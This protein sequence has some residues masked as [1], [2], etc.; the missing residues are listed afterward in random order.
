[1]ARVQLVRSNVLLR[2]LVTFVAVVV[3]SAVVG[4]GLGIVLNHMFGTPKPKTTARRAPLA[5][6]TA[7]TATSPTASAGGSAARTTT[8]ASPP[9]ENTTS[10]PASTGAAGTANPA[11]TTLDLGG[12]VTLRVTQASLI[13]GTTAGAARLTVQATVDN[14]GTAV[15]TAPIGR[16]FIRYAGV[17]V[18]PDP[19][20]SAVAGDLLKP[21]D[22][23]KSASG[24][25]HFE[26]R[27][28]MAQA[29][30]GLTQAAIRFGPQTLT[31][32]LG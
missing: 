24:E 7:G 21:I 10:V 25:L 14:A 5:Q 15:A 18:R 20:A 29:V 19:N 26:T 13:A 28:A 3:V 8:A 9:P 1:M 4:L 27:G 6:T 12:Q 2:E 31:V 11:R 30:K 23:G 22:P 17:T 16:L 32:K